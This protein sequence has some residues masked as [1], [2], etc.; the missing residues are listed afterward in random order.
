MDQIESIRR[1][2]A[3]A[4]NTEP[5]DRKDLESIYGQVWSTDE[6]SKEFAVEGFMAPFVI[7]KRRLDGQKGSLLFQHSP[8]FYYDFTPDD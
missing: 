1:V 4:I 8:R 3:S 6:L 7:V 2:I 5:R